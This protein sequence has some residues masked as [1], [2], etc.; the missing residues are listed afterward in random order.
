MHTTSWREVALLR[1]GHADLECSTDIGK[2]AQSDP[3][4]FEASAEAGDGDNGVLYT[5][6]FYTLE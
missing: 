3:D 4:A 1:S 5:P 6:Q 2:R